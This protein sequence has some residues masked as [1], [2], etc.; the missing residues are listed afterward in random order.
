VPPVEKNP[1]PPLHFRRNLIAVASWEL[2]WGFGA[3][4]IAAAL[5]TAFLAQLTDSKTIIGALALTQIAG[6]PTLIIATYLNHK[7]KQ[8]RLPVAAFHAIQVAAYLVVG[9]VTL[10]LDVSPAGLIALVFIAHVVIYVSNGFA[11]PPTY[12]LLAVAFGRRYGTASGIQI[13]VNRASGVLGGLAAAAV[14]ATFPFPTNFGLCFAVGGA[15]LLVSNVAVMGMIEPE[16]PERPPPPPMSVYLSNLARGLRGEGDYLAFLGVVALLALIA[17]AQGFYVVYALE[18]LGFDLAFSGI[19]AAIA[20]ATNALGGLMCGP[21]GDVR[22]H[23][24]LLFVALILHALSLCLIVV[25]QTQLAFYVAL[26]LAGIATTGAAV[27]TINLA[28]DFAPVGDKGT[29]AAVMRLATGIATALSTL[30]GG[31]LIDAVGYL[32]VF[33][34]AIL[35]PLSGVVVT[36][37]FREPRFRPQPTPVAVPK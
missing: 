32:P 35:F 9:L 20:F 31:I 1:L 14:L 12:E 30:L 13:F 29:Y 27:A 2:V 17:M 5:V 24:A 28:V 7:M 26:G 16:Y 36:T 8:K 34:V 33:A 22:G 25:A 21:L 23:R 10:T 3:A 15:L 4:G 6:M 37:R 19:F 18:Q 11:V